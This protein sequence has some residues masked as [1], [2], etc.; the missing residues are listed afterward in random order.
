VVKSESAWALQLTKLGTDKP[1]CCIDVL[2]KESRVVISG[3]E[4]RLAMFLVS[5]VML[6]FEEWRRV[7][8]GS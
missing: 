8:M 3:T 4:F 5:E 7:D 1:C 6:D 2:F